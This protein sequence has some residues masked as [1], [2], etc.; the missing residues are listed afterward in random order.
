MAGNEDAPTISE[1]IFNFKVRT[2]STEGPLEDMKSC[3]LKTE[4]DRKK[5]EG[6]IVISGLRWKSLTGSIF[7]L[8]GELTAVSVERAS[9]CADLD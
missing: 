9:D 5:A 3:A 2:G 7:P 8:T 4:K 6:T 1:E